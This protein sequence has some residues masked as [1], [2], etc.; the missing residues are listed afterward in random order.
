MIIKAAEAAAAATTNTK[1]RRR[2]ITEDQCTDGDIGRCLAGGGQETPGG[3][4][5]PTVKILTVTVVD[6]LT[7]G[8][9][10]RGGRGGGA[11]DAGEP[12]Y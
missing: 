9:A 6:I 1:C 12:V 4:Y 2:R 11:G 5:L 7:V 10:S 3:R 8:V